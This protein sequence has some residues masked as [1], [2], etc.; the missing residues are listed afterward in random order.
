MTALVLIHGGGLDSR[1]WDRLLPLLAA[2]TIA[3]DLPGHGA[4]P[5]DLASVGF[6]D[7]AA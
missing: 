4:H 1:C 5:A 2:P 7:C 3:V 6:A